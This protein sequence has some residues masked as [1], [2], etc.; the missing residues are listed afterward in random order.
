MEEE[1]EAVAKVQSEWEGNRIG[2]SKDG[3]FEEPWRSKAE[4]EWEEKESE[5]EGEEKSYSQEDRITSRINKVEKW[6][7]VEAEEIGQDNINWS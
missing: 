6:E 1:K 5:N 2:T 4:I 3:G 7:K